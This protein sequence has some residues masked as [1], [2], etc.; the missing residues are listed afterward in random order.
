MQPGLRLVNLLSM[1]WTMK[2]KTGS[3]DSTLKENLYLL[4]S[5]SMLAFD[6]R[7][8]QS[9]T[10]AGGGTCHHLPRKLQKHFLCLLVLEQNN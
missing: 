2:M 10:V 6:M 3:R 9:C 1:I 8:G 5:M 4:K 7:K